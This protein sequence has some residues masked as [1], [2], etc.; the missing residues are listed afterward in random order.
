MSEDGLRSIFPR[1]YQSPIPAH[2]VVELVLI[3]WLLEELPAPAEF[4]QA[5]AMLS[6]WRRREVLDYIAAHDWT[7]SA[8]DPNAKVL[9]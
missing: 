2:W 8:C 1:H 3:N 9:M 4:A 6:G 7:V 5:L